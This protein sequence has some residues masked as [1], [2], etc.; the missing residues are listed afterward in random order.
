[1]PRRAELVGVGALA[2]RAPCVTWRTIP[3]CDTAGPRDSHCKAHGKSQI[4]L[5]Q[6]ALITC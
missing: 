3:D 1:M 2:Y 4:S 6:Y 5:C